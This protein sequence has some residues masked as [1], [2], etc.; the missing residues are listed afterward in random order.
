ML[1]MQNLYLF[2]YSLTRDS[3]HRV[4]INEFAFRFFHLDVAMATFVGHWQKSSS[5]KNIQITNDVLIVDAK[6]KGFYRKF[7]LNSVNQNTC[8]PISFVKLFAEA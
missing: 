3:L 2:L 4:K 5:E 7:R 6:E 1:L 8:H